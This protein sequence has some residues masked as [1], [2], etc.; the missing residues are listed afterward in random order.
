MVFYLLS[1]EGSDQQKNYRKKKTWISFLSKL[2]GRICHQNCSSLLASGLV[3]SCQRIFLC[4][5][6]AGCKPSFSWVAPASSQYLPIISFLSRQHFLPRSLTSPYLGK[7]LSSSQP[8]TFEYLL[9][10]FDLVAFWCILGQP[11]LW[12][13]ETLQL[14]TG[15]ALLLLVTYSGI[16][17][18]GVFICVW[19]RTFQ[20]S[21]TKERAC[22]QPLPQK[23]EKKGSFNTQTSAPSLTDQAV[24]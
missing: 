10:S 3:L 16:L 18:T 7:Q 11:S 19:G 22:A 1:V 17:C 9:L 5:R 14:A 6:L 24:L 4:I 23:Q 8:F 12:D 2:N 21:S 13:I 20:G 15:S